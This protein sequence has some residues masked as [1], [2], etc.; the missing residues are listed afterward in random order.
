MFRI[1]RIEIDYDRLIDAGETRRSAIERL[2]EKCGLN[3]SNEVFFTKAMATTGADYYEAECTLRSMF[4]D[5][6][7]VWK[8]IDYSDD[9]RL[10]RTTAPKD[11]D[12]GYVIE[13]GTVQGESKT[14]RLVAMPERNVAYQT[15]RYS[16]GLYSAL[17]CS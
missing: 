13:V 15:G 4:G 11:Y 12:Y 17:E 14:E 9:Y 1:V 6:G 2:Y 5:A 8:V 16:S 7:N 10:V 3:S